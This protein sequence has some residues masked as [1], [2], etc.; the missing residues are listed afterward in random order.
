MNKIIRRGHLRA[1]AIITTGL[2]AA[3]HS[4]A[5]E[6]NLRL[7]PGFMPDPMQ[8]TFVSGGEQE[9]SQIFGRDMREIACSGSIS[10]T[11]D[12]VM[13][14][15]DDFDF[16]RVWNQSDADTTLIIDGPGRFLLCDDDGGR[17]LNELIEHRDWRAGDYRIYVGSYDGGAHSYDL[18]VS[19][20]SGGSQ[21]HADTHDSRHISIAPGF[22]PD[23]WRVSF[24]SGG[25]QSAASIFET[26]M[27]GNHCRGNIASTPDHEMTLSASFSY[28]QLWT[29]A[30]GDTTLII[31]GPGKFLL[32]D[33]D[34]G[35]G[36][37]E[38]IEHAN[39]P[40]GDYR[41]YVGSYSDSYLS[42]QLSISELRS[43]GP[44]R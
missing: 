29:Q 2:L 9:A 16:L 18:F 38:H 28:L 12:H 34:S 1:F 15:T 40:A 3:G 27:L 7:S 6:R 4:Y 44:G 31:D 42:Y 32:C 13:T 23:P 43:Y 25:A 14:L 24:V 36:L 5:Q 30:D 8:R 11:P 20:L 33:D 21:G 26:D 19:E 17:G 35:N 39:W 37:N 10:Q 22:T 41:I